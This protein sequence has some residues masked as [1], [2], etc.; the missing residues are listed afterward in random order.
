MASA[1]G[2]EERVPTTGYFEMDE[3]SELNCERCG[4]RVHNADR[5]LE[6]HRRWH[7]SLHRQMA[8]DAETAGSPWDPPS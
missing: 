6:L 3:S 7:Q 2:D 1:G 4:A 5:T 8:A